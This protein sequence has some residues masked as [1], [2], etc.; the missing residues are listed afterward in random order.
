[1]DLVGASA[2]ETICARTGLLHCIS[3]TETRRKHG[4]YK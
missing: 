2:C 1:M 3:K 4:I